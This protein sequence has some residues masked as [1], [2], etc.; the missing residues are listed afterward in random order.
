MGKMHRLHSTISDS[1]YN[2][3]LEL[4]YTDLWGPAPMKSKSGFLYYVTFMDAH[5]R[6]TWIYLLTNKSETLHTFLQFKK[7]VELQFGCKI[8]S[9]QS[10]WGGE[11]RPFTKALND[12]GIVHRLICPHTHH[13]NGSIERK[14]RHIVELGLTLLSQAS[15]P[16]SYWEHAFLTAVYLINRLPTPVLNY[17]VPFAKLH[18]KLPDYKLFKVFGCAC[19]PLLRPYNQHKFDFRSTECTFIGYSPNHKGYKCLS[20]EG[21]V[22]ISKDVLFNEYKFP[23]SVQHQEQ[24]LTSPSTTSSPLLSIPTCSAEPLPVSSLLNIPAHSSPLHSDTA[25]TPQSSHTGEVFTAPHPHDSPPLNSTSDN[26]SQQPTSSTVPDQQISGNDT[27]DSDADN[28]DLSNSPSPSPP[29]PSHPMQT[30]SK[31]GIVKPR[32]FPSLL[33]THV[34]PTSVKQALAQPEWRAAMQDEYDALLKNG[35]W[36]LVPLPPNRTAIGCKWVFRV[37]EN[38][39]G[40]VQRYKARLVAKG[41]HQQPGFDYTETFSPVVKPITIRILLTLV[42]THNW[43]IQQLDVN[44]AFLNGILDE[45]VYMTQPPGFESTG[46]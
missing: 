34:E 22:Y 29:R 5:T 31:S 35:T 40:S 16:L 12:F 20:P 39:D 23:F 27:G 37:K 2:S 30:R 41:F 43:P 13:Q 14:H 8:K 7:M 9:I 28:G 11:Y 21:R 4:I 32:V 33:L 26:F 6:Y 3:P 44:N 15:M 18:G 25:A 45:E 17:D 10:D 46:L 36:S 38:P 42:V 19:F 1:V 24:P